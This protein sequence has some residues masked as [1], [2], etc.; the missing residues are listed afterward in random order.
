MACIADYDE[1]DVTDESYTIYW[2]HP[3]H[4]KFGKAKYKNYG[5]SVFTTRVGEGNKLMLNF[6]PAMRDDSGVWTCTAYDTD[7]AVVS[8][9]FTFEVI[10]EL[11]NN[12]IV[13]CYSTS[14]QL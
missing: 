14:V 6:K 1:L 8:K 5:R 12:T 4:G 13:S 11:E 3:V 2:E 10:G 7:A 9:N